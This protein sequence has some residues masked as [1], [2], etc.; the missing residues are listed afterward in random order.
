MVVKFIG[1]VQNAKMKEELATGRKQGG[2]IIEK[3]KNSFFID[4]NI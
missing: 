4:K 3:I 2:T 1:S